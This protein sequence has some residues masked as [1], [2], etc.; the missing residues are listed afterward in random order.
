MQSEN[1]ARNCIVFDFETT[2]LSPS[3]GDRAIE[4]GAV[5]LESG[6]VVDK[7]QALMDPGV[8]IPPFIEDFTGIRNSMLEGAQDAGSVMQDFAAWAGGR[9]LVA[10]N[11]SFDHRFLVAELQRVGLR[12]RG[13]IACSMLAARRLFQDAPDHKLGTLVARL[14]LPTDGTYHRALADA[15]MTAQLWLREVQA[16]QDRGVERVLFATMMRLC[17]TS[18]SQVADF[19]DRCRA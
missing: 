6:V 14:S 17:R 11:A 15:E 1:D 3:S 2:G 13:E 12:V 18:R 7:F 19:V 8:R 10:H 5:R 16:L 9:N 4:I